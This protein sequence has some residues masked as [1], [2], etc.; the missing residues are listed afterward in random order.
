VAVA[1]AAFADDTLDCGKKSLADAVRNINA[2]N[3]TI[4]FTGVCAGPILITTDGVTLK[5]V[6]TAIIDGGGTDAVTIQGASNVSLADLQ[7][8]NGA[9]GVAVQDGAHVALT[10]VNIHDNSGDGIRLQRTSSIVLS[11]I[12][13]GHNGRVGLLADDAVGI[14]AKGAT[15]TNNAVKDLQLTFGAHADLTQL[16]LGTYTCDATVLVRG[17]AG[18]ICPH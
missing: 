12:V 14:T 6:G 3:L 4:N 15:L 10:G 16:T 11:D 17:T 18:I 5:G 8:T 13:V 1:T 7:V 2:K 9:I